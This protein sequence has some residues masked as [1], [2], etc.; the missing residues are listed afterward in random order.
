MLENCTVDASIF[1]LC[2][3][4]LGGLSWAWLVV[5]GLVVPSGVVGL[6]VVVS[7]SWWVRRGVFVVRRVDVLVL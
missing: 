7:W 4:P 1:S 2:R 6:F 3:A 5:G